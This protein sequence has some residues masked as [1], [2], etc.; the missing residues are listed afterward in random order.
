MP[1]SLIG[2]MHDEK[3]TKFVYLLQSV[4]CCYLNAFIRAAHACVF[5]FFFQR[6]NTLTSSNSIC[7]N[8]VEKWAKKTASLSLKIIIKSWSFKAFV[9]IEVRRFNEDYMTSKGWNALCQR[10]KLYSIGELKSHGLDFD[11]WL[12]DIL[13]W[14]LLLGQPFSCDARYSTFF[15][16]GLMTCWVSFWANISTESTTRLDFY[17]FGSHVSNWIDIA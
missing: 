4:A 12:E 9:S 8:S 15:H 6:E 14:Q 3:A 13:S 11:G 5:I 16:E 10:I 1:P 17:R 2:A 7:I